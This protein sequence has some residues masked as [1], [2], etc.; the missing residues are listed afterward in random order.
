MIN[1]CTSLYG[2]LTSIFYQNIIYAKMD[3]RLFFFSKYSALLH[4]ASYGFLICQIL[5]NL[6]IKF[7]ENIWT[8]E[9]TN[10]WTDPIIKDPSGYRKGSNMLSGG[11]GAAKKLKNVSDGQS[12][13]LGQMKNFTQS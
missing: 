3:L 11:H 12:I 5:D 9:P 8:D 7:Q 2:C 6:L 10:G 13:L 4:T 1:E